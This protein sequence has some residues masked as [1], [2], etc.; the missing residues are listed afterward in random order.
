MSDSCQVAI[1]AA[2]EREVWPLVKE[3]P[4]SR[5]DFDGRSF[6]FF[7]KDGVVVVC[8]GIGPEA[9]RRAAEA[10]IT[11]YRPALLISA[12]FAGA[13]DSTLELGQIQKPRYVI[14]A[15]DGSRTD[16]GSGRGSLVSFDHVADAEQKARL[17]LAY[18]AQTIDMEAAAVARAAEAHGLRF[19]ACKVISDT[20]TS[21]LPPIAG[22]VGSDGKFH[23][24][25]F[26]AYVAV[27]PWLWF[28]V[29]RLAND[30]AMAANKLCSA[31][32]QNFEFSSRDS[33]L[34]VLTR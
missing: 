4:A 9:A 26:M 12:G 6:K 11:L 28:T 17:G 3:W 2:I 22:F 1:V 19:L 21:S 13:L 24:L 29:M 14:N 23:V 33:D 30:S 32:A 15:S 25:R 31:L 34:R 27:R 16:C 20:S 8:G 5:R 7:V 18:G 10:I